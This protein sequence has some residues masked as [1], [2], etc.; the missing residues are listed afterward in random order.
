MSHIRIIVDGDTLMDADPGN[1]RSTPPDIESLKLKTG[2][3]PW[4]IALMGAV[5]E[6]ATL[7]MANLPAT[8]TTIVVTTRDNGWTLDVEKS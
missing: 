2:G 6:A 5:A 8:D 3:Q 4:G 1:W 7:S